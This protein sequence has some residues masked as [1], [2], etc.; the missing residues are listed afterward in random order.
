MDAAQVAQVRRF[1]RVVTQRVGALHDD[2]LSRDRSLGQA[3]LLWEIGPDGRELRGLRADLDL[4]AAYVSRLLRSL[5][6]DGLVVVE[7]AP[8]DA[9]VRVA[10]LTRKG[11]AERGL[12]DRRS[13][14]LAT[15]ILEPLSGRQRE[16]LTTAMADVERL[17]TASLVQVDPRDPRDP[18]ARACIQAYYDELGRRF[19]AGFDPSQSLSATED[20]LTPPAGLLLV[21]SLR[22]DAVGCG[23]LKL[24]GRRPAELKRMWVA[25]SARGLGVGRRILAELESHARRLGTRTVRLETNRSLTEAIA[26]YRSAGYDE[27]AAFNDEPYAHHWFQKRL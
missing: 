6:A 2:Y 15:S 5:E 3:R 12:L 16:R 11:R 4:D 10:R 18:V 24:H 19:D 25:P 27:V 1:N 22:D 26:L 20:E 17:L 9:R 23:A 7:P 21:A 14:D 13:D 8:G